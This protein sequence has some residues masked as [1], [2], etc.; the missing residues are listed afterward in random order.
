MEKSG[1]LK[2]T[3]SKD[4]VSKIKNKRRSTSG[5]SNDRVAKSERGGKRTKIKTGVRNASKTPVKSR[6]SS[7]SVSRKNFDMSQISSQSKAQKSR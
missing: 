2:K 4:K 1:S 5:N 6:E 7:N 3:K